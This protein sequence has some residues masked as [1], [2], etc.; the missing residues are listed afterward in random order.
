[1]VNENRRDLLEPLIKMV[2]EE[3]KKDF[4][5]DL[6][7]WEVHEAKLRA[8]FEAMAN[9]YQDRLIHACTLIKERFKFS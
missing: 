7:S 3:E 6:E 4:K 8:E 5:S 1:M 2:L 9:A